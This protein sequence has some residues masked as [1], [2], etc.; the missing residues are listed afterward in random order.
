[1]IPTSAQQLAEA[2]GG[3]LVG[4][5]TDPA[6]PD[7]PV[8][9]GVSLDSRTVG[10]GELFVAVK[11]ERHDGYD[12]APAAHARGAVLVLA[13]RPV[14][15]APTLVVADPV[16]ALG[17]I[18]A[19]V[20]ARLRA[21][22]ALQVVAIT[23]S[24]GKT[25]TKDLLGQLLGERAPTV[26]PY[27]SYNN[28][29]GLPTTVLRCDE[30]TRYL[31]LEMGTRAPGDIRRLTAIA[32]PDIGV[33]LG[34]GSAHV[35]EFGTREAI[36]RAKAELVEALSPQGVAVL[37]AA[38]PL[39]AAMATRTPARVVTFGRDVPADVRATDVELGPMA[40]PAFR[41]HVGDAG[42]AAVR[43]ALHG[44]P[45]VEHAL[46]A[47][48]VLCALGEH[49]PEP[50]AAALSRATARSASRMAV[51]TTPGGVVVID[52]AYNASPESVAA[53]LRSLVAIA[54]AGGPART[55]AVLGEMRELGAQSAAAHHRI[56]ELAAELGISRVL[57]VGDGAGGIVAGAGPSGCDAV[58][59]PHAALEVLRA[60]LRAGDVVLVKASRAVGLERVA[61]ALLADERVTA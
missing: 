43:L 7:G 32:P 49:D 33:E 60:E 10:P 14:P 12:H 39:V 28:D 16:R 11:G 56:G 36:A 37:N 17:R 47:A 13:D 20:L 21:A 9:A 6:A 54:G 26:A 57:A 45:A 3:R 2:T 52:D 22:G 58:A 31:V 27:G 48:A 1:M 4:V 40:R 41:L 30:R 50:I 15:Q 25:G 29:I 61:A 46:A 5:A 38:D 44:E 51:A 42:S 53:A 23:G 24:V 59:D 19:S 55:F 35:G 8:V 34:V 18:A